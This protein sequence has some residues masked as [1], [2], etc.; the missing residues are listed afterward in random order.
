MRDL[1]IMV[2][3]KKILEFPVTFI[4]MIFSCGVFGG[5]LSLFQS[6]LLYFIVLFPLAF[7]SY[8]ALRKFWHLLSIMEEANCLHAKKR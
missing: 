5:F 6:T 2:K 1:T 3:I 8:L 4:I 7:A